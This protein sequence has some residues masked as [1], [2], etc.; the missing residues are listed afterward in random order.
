MSVAAPIVAPK[1]TFTQK[2]SYGAGSTALG[3]TSLG[4]SSGLLTFFMDKVIGIPAIW[5]GVALM[6]TLA[7]DAIFDPLL[8]QWS[9]GVRSKYGRRH[10]FM[11]VSAPLALILCFFF[12]HPP[13]HLG[14][15]PL[16][17]YMIT[18]LVALRVAISLY[19]VPS[20]A[21]APEMT[22]DFHERT[23][24]FSYRWF[25]VVFGGL[26]MNVLLYGYFLREDNG[27]RSSI[28]G[29][30]QWGT[31]AAVV[32]AVSILISA[33]GTLS[34]LPHLSR[35]PAQS[36]SVRETI[37]QVSATIRNPS[38][39]AVMA[40]GLISGITTGLTSTLSSYFYYYLWGL[41]PAQVTF[42][43]LAA[44]VSSIIAVAIAPAVSRKYGK[45]RSMITL[46]YASVFIGAIPIALKLLNL[47]PPEG[48]LATL[49]LL[50]VDLFF[51]S[52]LGI[53][54]YIIVSSMI[55]DVV[56]DAAVK[57]GQ[58]SEGLLFAANGLLPKLTAGIGAF[59]GTIL[60]TLVGLS[61]KLTGNEAPDPQL[62]RHL[63]MAYLPFSLILSTGSLIA[64][65]FYKIDQSTH[66]RNLETLK[67]AAATADQS[68]IDERGVSVTAGAGAAGP[69]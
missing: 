33:F 15:G 24:L 12:W 69:I 46:F 55:A 32:I 4:L 45:K 26:A 66:E 39:V 65:S 34:R 48:S 25:F 49:V 27:G 23:N 20:A 62:M 68:Q 22:T 19:E 1:L 31:L 16:F 43:T 41:T 13:A 5:V 29:Y 50:C 30:A 10:P 58:R 21:L 67:D 37:K 56:E 61:G 2:L 38:L 18:T 54:G 52:T 35:P 53:M 60:L 42:I 47:A 11:F 28:T 17:A 63:A 3:V 36:I 9:D 6:V 51:T 40:S 59:L 8:G 57:T 14:V 44:G 7:V 64:I